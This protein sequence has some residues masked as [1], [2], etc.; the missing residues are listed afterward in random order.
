MGLE[1]L[2]ELPLPAELGLPSPAELR[3]LRQLDA[4]E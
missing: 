3:L 4:D 2:D 1:S